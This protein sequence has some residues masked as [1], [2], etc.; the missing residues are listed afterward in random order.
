MREYETIPQIECY[1]GQLNQVFL[2]LLVN[3]VDAVEEAQQQS[4]YADPKE[5]LASVPG[6]NSDLLNYKKPQIRIKT[7]LSPD[8]EFLTIS[9]KDNGL[10][11]TEDMQ[12]RLFD[13]FFTT[14]PVGKGTGLGLSIS[15]QIVVENHGGQLECYST[16]DEGT[17]FVIVLP[18]LQM[19]IAA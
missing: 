18:V 3:A 6:A 13:P 15:Y 7:S 1:P 14:K 5:L 4:H 2:N 8:G 11:I 12:Q 17:E 16:P 19:V 9:I 10:G